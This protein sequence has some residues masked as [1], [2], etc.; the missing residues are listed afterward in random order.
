MKKVILILAAGLSI[1]LFSGCESSV[2]DA[3]ESGKYGKAVLKSP[4]NSK[5]VNPAD[6]KVTITKTKDKIFTKEMSTYGII[7]KSM[8]EVPDAF[9]TDVAKAYQQMFSQTGS[10]DSKSQKKVLNALQQYNAM[11][12]VLNGDHDKLSAEANKELNKF[13]SEKYSVCDVI[14][15]KVHHQTM[16]VVE[17]LLHTITDVGLFY[18]YPNEWAFNKKTSLICKSMENAVQKKYFNL[19]SYQNIKKNDVETYQRVIVQEY[20]Y[21]II[22]TYWNLQEPYGLN[23]VGE[24]S[25]KNQEE[26]KQK[27][28]DAYNLVKNTIDKIMKAPST[29]ILEKLKTYE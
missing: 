21:W 15:Y 5:V 23:E 13:Q 10:L 14:S 26:L 27:L 19:S 20:A 24:W 22:T 29:A 9:L 16:E 11:L 7:F 4:A 2:T 6:T 1:L 25:I 3:N 8:N 12:P 18:A 17:H 28:P